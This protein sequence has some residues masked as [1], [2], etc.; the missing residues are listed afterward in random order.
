MDIICIE[1]I[2]ISHTRH[3]YYH[4]ASMPLTGNQNYPGLEI[5]PTSIDRYREEHA[6]FCRVPLCFRSITGKCL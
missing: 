3:T 1:D 4:S 5:E 2:I 6:D